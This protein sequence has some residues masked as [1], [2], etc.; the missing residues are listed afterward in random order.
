[1]SATTLLH[2]GIYTNVRPPAGGATTGYGIWEKDQ[3][4]TTSVTVFCPSLAP[5]RCW[6]I[7][8]STLM[9]GPNV[10]PLSVQADPGGETTSPQAEIPKL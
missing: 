2:G 3:E 1:M 8:G 4:T 6:V 7:I 5:V 9:T 10:P